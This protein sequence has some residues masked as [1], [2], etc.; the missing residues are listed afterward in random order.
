MYVVFSLNHTVMGPHSKYFITNYLGLES[1]RRDVSLTCISK[2]SS[3]YFVVFNE[4]A[5]I[6]MAEKETFSGE[7]IVIVCSFVR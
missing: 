5:G 6:F 1:T 4:S 3:L 7:T 2:I